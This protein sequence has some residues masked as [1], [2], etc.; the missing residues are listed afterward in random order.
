M[1][2]NSIF[3]KIILTQDTVNTTKENNNTSNNNTLNQ[4]SMNK[5]QF[6]KVIQDFS[7]YKRKSKILHT[8]TLT[9]NLNISNN[10]IDNKNNNNI[11]TH[12]KPIVSYKLTRVNG[13]ID[14]SIAGE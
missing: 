13:D 2:N 5:K 10:I 3:G 11:F 1:N 6:E 8:E 12:K 4:I 7:F 9:N 14:D